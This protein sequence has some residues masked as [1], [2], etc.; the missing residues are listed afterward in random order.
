MT[1]LPDRITERED[2]PDDFG[3]TTN[4]ARA[5][6]DALGISAATFAR[7]MSKAFADA[8]AG[9]KKFDDVLRQLALRLFG[10][11]CRAIL[12]AA[13]EES[14]RRVRRSRHNRRAHGLCRQRGHCKADLF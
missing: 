1:F 4:R 13:R 9:G 2:F 7:A 14:C 8:T 6:T 10:H 12:P 5:N 3:R 11:G